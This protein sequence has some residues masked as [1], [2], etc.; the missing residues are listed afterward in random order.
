M[1]IGRHG[2]SQPESFYKP[3][4]EEAKADLDAIFSNDENQGIPKYLIR[5][6]D[7]ILSLY[8]KTSTGVLKKGLKQK[9]FPTVWPRFV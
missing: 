1:I 8:G 7:R 2:T 4:E 3:S 6:H 5:R 9:C